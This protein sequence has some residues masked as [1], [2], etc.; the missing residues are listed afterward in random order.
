MTKSEIQKLNN[1]II[2]SEQMEEIES[3][4]T[5][6]RVESLGPSWSHTGHTWYSVE[7]LDGTSIDVFM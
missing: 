1:K 7:F 3:S 6:E 4:E 5:V 2:T